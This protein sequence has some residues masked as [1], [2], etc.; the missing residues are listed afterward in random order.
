MSGVT[1]GRPERFGL[2]QVA[3]ALRESGG[4]IGQAGEL[5]GVDRRTVRRYLQRHPQLRALRE[6]LVGEGYDALS[7]TPAPEREGPESESESEAPEE[8]SGYAVGQAR[9]WIRA[10]NKKP[11]LRGG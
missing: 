8:A 11:K 3:D 2:A 1:G 5:L 7:S 6:R 4:L 10:L 9:E